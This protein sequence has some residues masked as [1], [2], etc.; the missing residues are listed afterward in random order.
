MSRFADVLNFVSR[1]PAHKASLT[2]SHNPHKDLY[3][4]VVQYCL[5]EWSQ[6]SP[7]SDFESIE[8]FEVACGLDDF[9]EIQWYPNSPVGFFR[10][11]A[12]SL[13]LCIKMVEEHDEKESS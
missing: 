5:G 12:S 8:D 4:T 6:G 7:H 13:D 11:R 9:W 2:I 3:E 1:L 10:V